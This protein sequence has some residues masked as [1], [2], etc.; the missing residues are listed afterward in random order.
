ME[1]RQGLKELLWIFNFHSKLILWNFIRQYNYIKS[2]QNSNSSVFSGLLDNV[3]D[4]EANN[5]MDIKLWD[6]YHTQANT[7]HEDHVLLKIGLGL[8]FRA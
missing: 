7:Q 8:C 2:K 1:E 4:V 3:S 6:N 5:F